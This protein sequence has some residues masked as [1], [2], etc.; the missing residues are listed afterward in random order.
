[1]SGKVTKIIFAAFLQ[2]IVVT[3]LAFV[4]SSC[5]QENNE[6]QPTGKCVYGPSDYRVCI[7][8]TFKSECEDDYDGTWY[9]GEECE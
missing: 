4:I 6:P 5:S 2:V 8:G 1:M 3:V 7:D 9:E